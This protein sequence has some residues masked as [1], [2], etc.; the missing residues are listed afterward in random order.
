[1]KGAAHKVNRMISFSAFLLESV[2]CAVKQN[3]RLRSLTNPYLRQFLQLVDSDGV[4]PPCR[5][6]DPI[7]S[8]SDGQTVNF[9]Y[10]KTRLAQTA[11]PNGVTTDYTY[12]VNGWLNGINSV[13]PQG[14]V[15]TRDYGFD[16]I[17]NILTK[18]SEHGSYG[19]GYG[20]TNQL[21]SADNPQLPDEAYSYDQ[22]G[23][24]LTSQETTGDWTYNENTEGPEGDR[25]LLM[26]G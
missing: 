9:S 12:E 10:D 24:R 6:E 5:A 11:F 19:Y 4:R 7:R 15:L 25:H 1:M 17:G 23:N 22:V 18:S 2:Q 26:K 14:T 13:G 8:V 21:T 16:G 3:P 20:A